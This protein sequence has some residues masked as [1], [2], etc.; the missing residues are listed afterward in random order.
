MLST[1]KIFKIFLEFII[2]S[3]TN[4]KY[5]YLSKY[6]WIKSFHHYGIRGENSDILLELG[7]CFQLGIYL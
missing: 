7:R 5:E 4:H 2:F 3:I 6:K 1:F